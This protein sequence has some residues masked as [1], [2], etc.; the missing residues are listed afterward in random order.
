MWVGAYIGLS[1][2]IPDNQE[3]FVNYLAQ[4]N[5]I[6]TAAETPFVYIIGDYSADLSQDQHG[7][8]TQSFGKELIRVCKEEILIISDFNLLN[9]EAHTFYMMHTTPTYG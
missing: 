7:E 5:A 3:E 4:L 9:G 8:I 2:I 6:I 1:H